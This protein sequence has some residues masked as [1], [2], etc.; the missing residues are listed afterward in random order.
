MVMKRLTALLTV[1]L[2]ASFARA[3]LTIYDGFNY[4]ATGN[5]FLGTGPSTSAGTSSS[6]TCRRSL[7]ARS[8]SS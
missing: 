3:D 4:D 6:G 8:R 5:P 7:S 2:S 1:L